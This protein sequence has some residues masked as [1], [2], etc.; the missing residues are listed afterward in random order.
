MQ[1]DNQA[2]ASFY[3]KFSSLAVKLRRKYYFPLSSRRNFLH[4]RQHASVSSPSVK[5]HIY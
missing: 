4:L 1:H 2:T 3:P 5:L